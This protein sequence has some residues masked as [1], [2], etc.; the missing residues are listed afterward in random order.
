MQASILDANESVKGKWTKVS[1]QKQRDSLAR[2]LRADDLYHDEYE[3]VPNLPQPKQVRRVFSRL[4][5]NPFE[6]TLLFN[7]AL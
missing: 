1:R 6:S 3:E 4:H 2:W 7:P 5:S